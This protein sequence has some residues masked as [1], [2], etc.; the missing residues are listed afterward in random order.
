MDGMTIVSIGEI[1]WDVFPDHEDLGGASFNFAYHA[2]RLGH[3]VIFVSAVG[4]D[5]LG[6]RAL[7]Q[8]QA[9]GIDTSFIR[10]VTGVGTGCVDVVLDAA[11]QPSF[12][13]RRPAAYDLL[14]LSDDE[15]AQIVAAEPEW[16]CF[17]TLSFVVP[18]A[19]ATLHRLLAACPKARRFYD[20]NLRRDNWSDELV[21]ELLPL[22]DAVKLNESE[23]AE[24]GMLLMQT[25]AAAVCITRAER[26]CS[27]NQ[28][29][30]PGYPVEVVDAVGAGDSFSAAYLHG[31]AQGWPLAEVGDF[32]NRVGALVASRRGGTPGWTLEEARALKRGRE[33]GAC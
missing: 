24:L 4:D 13:L 21:S 17:G 27:M 30:V 20:V 32:A 1:L 18:S 8:A 15:L 6:R 33:T 5:E 26:G 29:D 7:A 9:L 10:I 12:T 19:L 2:S 11:R 3:R 23:A 16:I 22:A 14:S 28:L 25:R 31:L